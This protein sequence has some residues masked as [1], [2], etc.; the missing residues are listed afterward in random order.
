MA[1][2][3]RHPG[4]GLLAPLLTLADSLLVDVAALDPADLLEGRRQLVRRHPQARLIA[5]NVD[6]LE[7]LKACRSLAFALF[8]GACV[9]HRRAWREPRLDSNR[10]VVA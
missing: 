1:S 4:R 8:K 7:T 2:L 3:C 9:T 5:H 10:M 6:T